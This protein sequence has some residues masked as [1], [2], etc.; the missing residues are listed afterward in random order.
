MSTMACW[1]ESD[2]DRDTQPPEPTSRTADLSKKVILAS[3]RAATAAA[4]LATLRGYVADWSK[5]QGE[6][7]FANE[8]RASCGAPILRLHA[9]LEGVFADCHRLGLS[10][11]LAGC[12]QC[13]DAGLTGLESVLLAYERTVYAVREDQLLERSE[14]FRNLAGALKCFGEELGCS[15]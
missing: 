1:D 11:D 7:R 13:D 10:V 8:D 14:M 6:F 2:S 15:P 9:S 3:E 4:A 5:A 12:F